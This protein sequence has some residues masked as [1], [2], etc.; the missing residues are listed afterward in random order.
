MRD[1]GERV[2]LTS[3]AIR[4]RRHPWA[5]VGLWG[6][7]TLVAVGASYPAA[8]L[9]CT[10]YGTGPRSDAPLWDAGAHPLLDF[11]WHGARGIAPVT[12]AAKIALGV[13]AVAG[14]LPMAG[15]M[16][17]MAHG[18]HDRRAAGFVSTMTRALRA[19]PPLLAL[20][21]IASIAQVSVIAIGFAAGW[22][23]EAW[24]HGAMGENR[25][26][27]MG[28][29]VGFMFLLAASGIGVVHDL[30][31]AAVVRL[32]TSGTRAFVLGAQI[33]G[34]TPLPLWWS[35]AWRALAALTLVIVASVVATRIGGRGGAALVGLALVHQGVVAWRLAWRA[36]WLAKAL[37]SV[38]LEAPAE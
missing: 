37:R 6:W 36:S 12:A 26:E 7:Q 14:L 30:A 5:L 10:T 1:A 28:V 22:A 16:V 32:H 33:F 34:R 8:A 19:M 18:A 4:A 11:V 21:G 24:A 13:G 38:S 15:V 27:R 20:F 25:A 29:T 17:A 35:W 9:V 2:V 23:V 3:A 31:R